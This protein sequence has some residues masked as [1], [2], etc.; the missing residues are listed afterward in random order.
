M[1]VASARDVSILF[2]IVKSPLY[3]KNTRVSMINTGT[4]DTIDHN[5]YLKKDGIRTPFSSEMD[6]TIKFGAFPI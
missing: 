2:S 3:K 4:K 1:R 5:K 6:F